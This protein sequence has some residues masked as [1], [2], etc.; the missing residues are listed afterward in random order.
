[1]TVDVDDVVDPQPQ[2]AVEGGEPARPARWV[3]RHGWVVPAVLVGLAIAL[4]ARGVFRAPG[5]PMEEGFMLVFPQRLLEGDIPNKDF[6]HLYGPGSIWAIAG[7]FKAFGIS[8]WTERVF[9]FLQLVALIAGVTH[10]GYRWGR[11]TAAIAGATTAIV[12][13]PPIGVT[14]LAW[15]GGM[16]LALWAVIWAVRP[17]DATPV[18][19]V[20]AAG[21][22]GPEAGDRS[23]VGDGVAGDDQAAGDDGAG[24]SAGAAV[25][26][27]AERRDGLLGGDRTPLVA[28]L[29]AGVALLF[30]PDLVVAL[31]LPLGVLFV[32]A[33][34]GAARRRLL[35]GGA[36]GVSPYL[37][38]LAF[39]GPGN[40]VR[41][42]VLEPV[43]DLRPGRRLPFPPP[44][45]YFPSFL[46]RAYALREFAWPLPE[47]S[48]TLQVALFFWALVLVCVTLLVL[49]FWAKR[50]GSV[51]GWRLVALALLA[52]GLLP[53]AVQ[54]S[55]TAHLSWVSCIPFG[56]LPCFIAEALRLRSA[57][58]GSPG[59]ETGRAAR[60][61]PL[62]QLAPLALMLVFP[63]YTLRWYADYVGQSAGHD[64]VVANISHRGRDFY[65]G[66]PA[67]A[68]AAEQLLDDI[69]DV[70]EPG[71]RL[72]VGT[73]DLRK[74]PYS[75]AFFYFLLPQLTP[76][77]HYIEMD[78][79]VANADDSGLADE[80]RHADVLILSTVYD[81]WDEPN[82]SQDFG[83]DEPNKVVD[84][85]FCLVD[86]YGSNN[87][88]DGSVRP[89]YELYVRCDTGAGDP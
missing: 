9:G 57:R 44:T 38:H 14:A 2:A 74:T 21:G 53:Q 49:G 86:A 41:G 54:R 28:G 50:A 66:R 88:F 56:L 37:L 84:E 65:Y 42:M 1:V 45:D 85:D 76:G 18:A 35:A 77:T 59:A 79:G 33:Y 8:L 20:A 39:A 36:L 10:I 62:A 16:A 34:D 23:E 70:T 17:F 81:D 69:E 72:I 4:P 25:T 67:V 78:P 55:D 71:D 63:A 12:I 61:A 31:G 13:I 73:G 46:N 87:G 58:A 5:P 24:S 40:A 19:G 75:E 11:W 48:M 52:A 89:I 7:F 80:M 3:D 27:H 30:R 26:T 51:H 29:L 32:F 47:P 68:E 43:F 83:S 60:L 6:L 82:T 15:V 22:T 64:R